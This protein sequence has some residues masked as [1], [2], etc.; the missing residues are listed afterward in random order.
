MMENALDRA[1]K[2]LLE[3]RNRLK[4]LRSHETGKGNLV[5]P[6]ERLVAELREL[7]G[8]NLRL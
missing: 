2:V 6:L 5:E 1:D 3:G 4:D 8:P 7:G